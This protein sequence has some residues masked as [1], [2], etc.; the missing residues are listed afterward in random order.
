MSWFPIVL[1]TLGAE[2]AL[3]MLVLI[4]YHFA[5]TG[6]YNPN[7]VSPRPTKWCYRWW[8]RP[9]AVLWDALCWPLGLIEALRDG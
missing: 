2:Y 8:G 5:E 3:G 7:M 9:I 4:I 6:W 1:L